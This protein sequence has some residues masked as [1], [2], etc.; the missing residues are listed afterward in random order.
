MREATGRTGTHQVTY[1]LALPMVEASGPGSRTRRI[2]DLWAHILRDQL[3]VD[4]ATRWAAVRDGD[5]PSRG[6][7]PAAERALPA[8]V[9]QLL[10]NRVGLT[11]QQIAGRPTA[12]PAHPIG[13]RVMQSTMWVT[14]ALCS[15]EVAIAAA[16]TATADPATTAAATESA[17]G[18]SGSDERPLADLVLHVHRQID[19]DDDLID[20]EECA[21]AC[22]ACRDEGVGM[23]GLDVADLGDDIRRSTVDVHQTTVVIAP[24]PIGATDAQLTRQATIV[25]QQGARLRP[26]LS[27][28]QNAGDRRVGVH[29]TC[30][31]TTAVDLVTQRIQSHERHGHRRHGGQPAQGADGRVARAAIRSG[32]RCQDHEHHEE[33]RHGGERKCPLPDTGRRS[34]C[35]ACQ[36]GTHAR[37]PNDSPATSRYQ[38]P[39]GAEFAVVIFEVD[40]PVDCTMLIPRH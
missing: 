24:P 16:P 11:E 35:A 6:A 3:D 30:R 10:R 15:V 22:R 28:R 21:T 40:G 29:R 20:G 19:V 17:P 4:D 37:L 18:L 27:R 36:K 14:T 9:A 25:G 33:G 5:R 34:C 13:G 7:A 8:E 2:D 32:I 26:T 12:R 39:L 38:R 31:R 23:P 1:E